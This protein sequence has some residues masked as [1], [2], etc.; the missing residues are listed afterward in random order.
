[1]EKKEKEEPKEKTDA[2]VSK[3]A[4]A[5]SK[6]DGKTDADQSKEATA[7]SKKTNR[8]PKGP[9]IDHVVM[10]FPG[11]DPAPP[12][13]PSPANWA[14]KE[15]KEPIKEESAKSKEPISQT[16]E[17][18]T[19]MDKKEEKKAAPPPPPPPPPPQQVIVRI[20]QPKTQPF[21]QPSSDGPPKPVA[22]P[23]KK[24]CCP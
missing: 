7:E 4:T 20:E 3:D 14:Q 6:K 9:Q 22:Q 12:P 10:I 1:E 17:A 18:K 5:P 21:S 23:K 11:S 16:E 19:E 2:D 13:A 15:D 24:K 8:Q